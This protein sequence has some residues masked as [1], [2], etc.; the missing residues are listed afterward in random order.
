MCIVHSENVRRFKGLWLGEVQKVQKKIVT[1][2]SFEE[3]MGVHQANRRERALPEG[4]GMNLLATTP[5]R[6]N[7]KKLD[8]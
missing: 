1:G 3:F 5:P 6:R 7:D 8:M 2:T 4:G